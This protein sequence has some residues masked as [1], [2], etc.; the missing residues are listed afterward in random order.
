MSAISGL[1]AVNKGDFL[2]QVSLLLCCIII[3]FF[4]ISGFVS[5]NFVLRFL[6]VLMMVVFGI[7]A[8]VGILQWYNIHIF[9]WLKANIRERIFST[10]DNPNYCGCFSAI[11]I[12]MSLVFLIHKRAIYWRIFSGMILLTGL[13]FLILTESRAGLVASVVSVI[14]VLVVLTVIKNPS[15]NKPCLRL[16]FLVLII[17]GFIICTLVISLIKTGSIGWIINRAGTVF[18]T[19]F[20]TNKMR[21]L[22]WSGT[23]KM[24]MDNVFVG[25]GCGNFDEQYVPYRSQEEF[26]MGQKG[27]KGAEYRWAENAHNTYLQIFTETGI[28]GIVIFLFILVIAGIKTCRTMRKADGEQDLFFTVGV[29][30]ALL[31]FLIAGFFNTLNI[32]TAHWS[33]FWILMAML[34]ADT[35]FKH[36]QFP[37]WLIVPVCVVVMALLFY[38]FDFQIKF[39]HSDYLRLEGLR[40][41]KTSNTENTIKAFEKGA[42]LNPYNWRVQFNLATCYFDL[43]DLEKAENYSLRVLSICPYCV[44]GINLLGSIYMKRGEYKKAITYFQKAEA[45]SPGYWATYFCL[46]TLFMKKKSLDLSIKS[47]KKALQLKPDSAKTHFM[48]GL[49]Y[50]MKNN[51]RKAINHFYMAKKHSVNI[52]EMAQKILLKETYNRMVNIP[53]YQQIFRPGR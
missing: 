20:P 33:I 9:L 7:V 4:M 42:E 12:P 14:F 43:Q 17:C 29:S 44:P 11:F 2:I 30:S 8:I 36:I 47:Y 40:L 22:T 26:Q 31:G 1:V 10:L 19:Q 5:R 16:K 45:L 24:G 28:G 25:V 34:G 6:P 46:G 53:E 38:S 35:K 51:H 37:G 27:I 3:Y 52:R 21:L 13:L 39:A 23:I 18:S 32:F 50:F 48:L 49:V 15:T 41:K